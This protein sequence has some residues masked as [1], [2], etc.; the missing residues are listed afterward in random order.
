MHRGKH[1]N[2]IAVE[3]LKGLILFKQGK[4]RVA[5]SLINNLQEMTL[6]YDLRE[7]RPGFSILS[8][9]NM[10]YNVQQKRLKYDRRKSYC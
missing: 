9:K 6:L 7:E 3:T 10:N 5:S 8:E 4:G 1:A 2:K